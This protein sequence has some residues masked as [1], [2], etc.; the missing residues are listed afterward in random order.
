VEAFSILPHHLKGPTERVRDTPDS[1]MRRAIDRGF[2]WV[3]EHVVGTAADL[4]VR[5]RY[6]VTGILLVVLLGTAGY[7]AGGHIAREAIPAID[8]DV[9]EAR[10]L[11][12]QG[13]PLERTELIVDQVVAAAEEV[14]RA[15]SPRQPGGAALLQSVQVRYAENVSAGE[16][17]PHVATVIVDLLS[18]DRRATTLDEITERWRNSIGPIPAIVALIIQEPGFGPQGIPI[19][20]RII[21]EDLEVMTAAA[22]EVADWVA[23]YAGAYNVMHDLRPGKPE[24]RIRMAQGA[25]AMGLTAQGVADQLRAG[26]LG[27]VASTIQFG[28]ETYDILARQPIQDR[29]SLDDLDDFTVTL[30]D[31]RQVPLRTVA[32][33]ETG[34][35]RRPPFS[36]PS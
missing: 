1:R 22:Q 31:G 27:T 35:K 10:V 32:M 16:K 19:E 29:D 33:V 9:L 14:D 15:L 4:A 5:W 8:G 6:G 30:P 3:R 28:G 11:M 23:G 34:A 20:V 24:L 12:P 26:F 21:G 18:A 17:G 2:A 25:H 36:A 13:T 7:M